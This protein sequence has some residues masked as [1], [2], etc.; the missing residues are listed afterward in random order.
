M[1]GELEIRSCPDPPRWARVAAWAT[2]ACVTPSAVWRVAVGFGADL[3][4][5]ERQLDRQDIPGSGTVYVVAL[6]VLSLGA[7]GMTL[8]LVRR[9]ADRLPSWVP[10]VGGRRMPAAV[11]VTIA[12]AGAAV[13]AWICALS[14]AN[15]DRVNGFA[16]Q[17]D[18]GWAAVMV[19][20]YAPALLWAPLLLAVTAD[21][22]WH[23]HRSPPLI[24]A[25]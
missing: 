3:G 18:S 9:G 8:M 16:D 7:A 10:G 12:C 22:Y 6:S 25:R 15:W 20:C 21:Y 5:S 13:V 14:V 24:R 1:G 2:V 4:W 19:A 11:V 23:R 17:P